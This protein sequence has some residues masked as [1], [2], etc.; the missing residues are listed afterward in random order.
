LRRGDL[1]GAMRTTVSV[2]GR[3][4]RRLPNRSV[5]RQA[6]P[7]ARMYILDPRTSSVRSAMV[8][9]GQYRPLALLCVSGMG[10]VVAVAQRGSW[11]AGRDSGRPTPSGSLIRW[12]P[13]A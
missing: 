8:H 13:G 4:W 5:L 11:C 9:A 2:A 12:H 6:N 1:R 3:L 7:S 10:L